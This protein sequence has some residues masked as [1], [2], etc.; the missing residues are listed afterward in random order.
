MPILT[1]LGELLG[2][3]VG[4]FVYH[5]LLLLAVEAALAMAW[6]EWQRA[7]DEQARRLL[8]AMTGLAGARVLYVGAALLAA[9][10]LVSVASLPPLERLA[11]TASICLLGWGVVRAGRTEARAWSWLFSANLLAVFACG[12]TFLFLWQRALFDRPGLDYALFWQSRVWS[13]WQMALS[14]LVGVAALRSLR[15]AAAGESRAPLATAIGPVPILFL[16][17]LLQMLLLGQ[18]SPIPIWERLSNLVAYPLIAVAI[19]QGIVGNLRLHAEQLQEIS[20]ASLD[21]IKSL[22]VL[23]EEARQVSGSLSLPQVLENAIHG[24]ARALDADQCAIV[25]L[26]ETEPGYVRLASVHNAQ[27]GRP[28]TP[29]GEA[30]T[31]PLDY[32]LTIQQAMRRKK[33]VIVDDP[34]NV[35]LRVLFNLLGSSEAGPLLVQPLLGDGEAIGAIVVGNSLTRRSFTPNEAKLCQSMAD[36]VLVALQN[37]Q[38][39]QDAQERIRELHRSLGDQRRGLEDMP[40]LAGREGRVG[41]DLPLTQLSAWEEDPEQ[42]SPDLSAFHPPRGGKG[43]EIGGAKP[44]SPSLRSRA[45]SGQGITGS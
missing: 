15:R 31:F 29:R 4:S 43:G 5:V 21:Q 44:R 2:S 23:V 3:P 41:A 42:P 14:A 9:G 25:L 16:G 35:Q 40:A 1:R 13:A 10:H 18:S 45:S 33:S 36:Q 24:V 12:G 6:E 19:Y 17:G 22:L 26:E 32:Q 34:D 38:R 28:L 8:I 39:Y 11:D 27:A 7:R 37:A 20:Q 30:V